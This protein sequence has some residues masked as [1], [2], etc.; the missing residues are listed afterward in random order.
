MSIDGI[1][2]ER[3]RRL[4]DARHLVDALERALLGG[5]RPADEQG[6][7][8][9]PT[10][11]G[12]LL[13]MPSEVSG[14]VGVKVL[15][16]APGNPAQGLP[17]IS[18]LYLLMDARTLRLVATLDGGELTLL[19]TPAVSALAARHM[20]AR[21]IRTAVVFGSGPQALAHIE[22][23]HALH[24][25]S[26]VVVAGRDS[27]RTERLVRRCA[28]EG[29]R[30]RA[31]SARDVR[32][33]DVVLCCTSAREPLFEAELLAPRTVVVAVG[34]HHPEARE[35]GDDVMAG[36]HVVVESR[37][38]ATTEA[39][40]VVQA[41]GHGAIEETG[42]IELADLVRGEALMD[43]ARPRVFKSVGM[44]WEDLV[45]AVALHERER[46]PR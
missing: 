29:L 27:E 30:A 16:L 42:L 10:S 2:P 41:L 12:E 24:G 34:S 13:L 6:R 11:H 23:F 46:A 35:L 4:A 32:G 25:L 38:V 9:R 45:V 31:G 33:A 8:S 40:D 15:G 22:T 43:D 21:P 14:H 36:A 17:T 37:T 39:G 18:G 7:V 28:D 44:A 19:R 5:L 3:M 1:G 26:D 20:A